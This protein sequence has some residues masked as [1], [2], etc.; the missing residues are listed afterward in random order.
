MRLNRLFRLLPLFLLSHASLISVS[1]AAAQ[2]P[3]TV[4]LEDLTSPEVRDAIRAGKTTVIIPS[5]GVEQNGPHMV[6]GKHN[7]VVK[8]AAERIARKLGNALVAPVLAFAPEGDPAHPAG[9]MLFPGTISLPDPYFREVVEAEG[10]SLKLAGFRNIVLLGDHGDSQAGLRAAADA[11]NREWKMA[12]V[13]ALFISEY[14]S[15]TAATT[16][17]RQQGE[18]DASIGTHAGPLD[19]SELM[20]VDPQGVRKD[21]LAR[22]T[23]FAG[24]GVIGD[25]THARVEYGK[26]LLDQKVDFAVAQIQKLTAG[27][28]GDK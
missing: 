8:Y 19:T 23:G 12:A 10:R 16:W 15:N 26:H 17:L 28:R 21:K 1:S 6:L 18:T 4:F 14:Y 2:T 5:G 11:L 9:H 20:A 24:N 3:D 7:I 22:G 27:A 25:A 13:R